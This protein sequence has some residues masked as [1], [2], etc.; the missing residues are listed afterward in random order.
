MFERVQN[1]FQPKFTTEFQMKIHL[2]RITMLNKLKVHEQ[3]LKH[4]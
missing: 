1:G 2:P 3:M 4:R